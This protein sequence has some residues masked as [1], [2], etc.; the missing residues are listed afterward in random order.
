MAE[1][2]RKTPAP[3]VP[4]LIVDLTDE[5]PSRGG[6]R[7]TQVNLD[8]LAQLVAAV[9]AD[10]TRKVGDG[11]FYATQGT[12]AS[13]AYRYRK[14]AADVHEVDLRTRTFQVPDDAKDHA[15]QWRWAV[16]LKGNG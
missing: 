15:G 14:A 1:R 16:S 10:A 12:A 11:L 2:K 13:I 4:S 8:L 6:G 9:Q 7:S 5:V 3:E